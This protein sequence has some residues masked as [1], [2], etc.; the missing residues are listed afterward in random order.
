MKYTRNY[1]KTL[2]KLNAFNRYIRVITYGTRL[3]ARTYYENTYAEEDD[4]ELD[5]ASDELMGALFN[6]IDER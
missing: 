4:P 5:D 3:I 6:G 2:C 1:I